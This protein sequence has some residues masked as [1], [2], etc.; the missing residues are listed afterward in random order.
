MLFRSGT[1]LAAA[2]LVKKMGGEVIECAFLVD[3]PD[4][5]GRERLEKAGL[6]VFALCE[7]EGD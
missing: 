3:L 7:F 5:G 1:A 4:I 2:T 6:P